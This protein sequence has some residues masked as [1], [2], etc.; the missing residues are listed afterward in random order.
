[1]KGFHNWKP[2]HEY[3]GS[4]TEL[5]TGRTYQTRLH[6]VR[7]SECHRVVTLPNCL[8]PDEVEGCLGT[9]A[10]PLQKKDDPVDYDKDADY[11]SG[12]RSGKVRRIH[13]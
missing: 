4:W 2:M 11:D 12:A 1:M 7:C 9:A 3:Q 10:R 5:D 6:D 13:G 8:L